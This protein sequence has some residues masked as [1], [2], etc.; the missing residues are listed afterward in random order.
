MPSFIR[1]LD[2]VAHR[3]CRACWAVVAVLALVA[4]GTVRA[5]PQVGRP[6]VSPVRLAVDNQIWNYH[7]EEAF[8]WITFN[9]PVFVVVPPGE[10][11][12]I[13]VGQHDGRIYEVAPLNNPS[14]RMFMDLSDRVHEESEGGLHGLAFHPR[15]QQNGQIFVTYMAAET[16]WIE[17]NRFDRLS[18]FTVS[19]ADRAGTSNSTSDTTRATEVIFIDQ[20]DRHPDHNAGDLHFGPDG[21]LYVSLGDEGGSFDQ[22]EN[23]QRIDLNF[24][25]GI[26]RI[27]VD[28]NAKNLDPNPHPAVTLGTYKVPSDNPWIQARSFRG[29]Q[30]DVT[31][32]RT[33]FYA[34]GMRNPWRFGFD[35][36]TGE[37]YC[38]DTGDHTR[39]EVNRVVKGGNYGYPILEGTV[40]GPRPSAGAAGSDLLSPLIEYGREQGGAIAG[41]LFYRG[42]R[43]PDLQGAWLISDFWHGFLGVVRFNAD[44]TPRPLEWIA[45]ASGISSF[46]TDPSN[47]DILACDYFGNRLLRLVAGPDPALGAVP[48]NLSQLGAFSD[49]STL[50]PNPGVVPYEVN[51]PF[52]SDGAEKQRWFAL[53]TATSVFVPPTGSPPAWWY[54]PGTVF[55][56]NL[57]LELTRGDPNS[58][59]RL[60]TRVLVINSGRVAEGFTYQWNDAQSDA[61]L[62]P[63][64]GTNSVYQVT[65]GTSTTTV[66]WRYPSRR[67][68]LSCHHTSA[69]GIQ[70]FTLPQ[71]NRDVVLNGGNVHQLQALVDAGYLQD[72]PKPAARIPAL[73]AATTLDWSREWRARS[74]LAVNCSPCHRPN[75]IAALNW[76]ADI[77][78]PLESAEI[79]GAMPYNNLG[80]YQSMVVYPGLPD[81]SVLYRRLANL[82]TG[83]MPPLANSVLNIDGIELIRDWI[84]QDT[85]GFTT[86]DDWLVEVMGPD[87]TTDWPFGRND[88]LD[89]DGYPNEYEW[90]AGSSPLDPS[91]E[92]DL[93]VLATGDN[94]QLSYHRRANRDYSIQWTVT[95]GDPNSW[96]DL[97]DPQNAFWMADV[98]KDVAIQLPAAPDQRFF[99]LTINLN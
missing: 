69:G 86:Y 71:L 1:I 5:D 17:T 34:V 97:D 18:R 6:D 91:P 80:D 29:I 38:N 66:N 92:L 30:L 70:G 3:F 2:A 48:Q 35:P 88:D 59:R 54:P 89:G 32:V 39:E 16:A 75:G 53:P 15:F 87:V 25:S 36:Q 99:R 85:P 58:R 60:E 55:I 84:T 50:S 81:H 65:D 19:A 24:F 10:T 44:G 49:L 47:G 61:V 68:C 12:R 43:Y 46:G 67:E 9:R 4:A 77:L 78:S 26:I 73:A 31:R 21:Y 52:W 95:P 93:G 82:G 45:W 37:L 76:N 42:P 14:V 74:F 7:L 40:T 96:Q 27:D 23:G 41:G 8:P 28:R 56:K 22:F 79:I 13:L 51:V 63:P 33:E 62:L 94:V 83:H 64:A 98:D 57:G 72:L 11:N 20:A 90:L